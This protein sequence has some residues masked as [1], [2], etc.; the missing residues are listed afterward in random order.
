MP[1]GNNLR[2]DTA[3]IP[4][5]KPVRWGAGVASGMNAL[6]MGRERKAYNDAM[7]IMPGDQYEAQLPG[8]QMEAN[9]TAAGGYDGPGDAW[10]RKQDIAAARFASFGGNTSGYDNVRRREAAEAQEALALADQNTMGAFNQLTGA[11]QQ[12]KTLFGNLN[13]ARQ[14]LE[15]FKIENPNWQTQ[16]KGTVQQME[17][18]IREI[19]KSYEHSRKMADSMAQNLMSQGQNRYGYVNDYVNARGSDWAGGNGQQQPEIAQPQGPA[20]SE[21]DLAKIDLIGTTHIGTDKLS[22]KQ[23]EA[24]FKKHFGRAGNDAELARFAEGI[25]SQIETNRDNA[26]YKTTRAGQEADLKNKLS[27]SAGTLAEM[28]TQLAEMG[29]L[30]SDDFNGMAQWVK[31]NS[32]DVKFSGINITQLAEM[33]GLNTLTAAQ[34]NFVKA[35]FLK[36]ANGLDAKVS[37]LRGKK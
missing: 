3:V 2:F 23:L 26:G 16:H 35:E 20:I 31:N 7:A 6:A 5:Y 22:P 17:D 24:M 12:A 28:E 14:N 13:A 37:S 21:E 29:K 32:P 36:I 9:K 15:N 8:N 19:Q 11:D 34:K 1:Q 27:Q 30:R 25:N 10:R 33:A 4:E 18:Q